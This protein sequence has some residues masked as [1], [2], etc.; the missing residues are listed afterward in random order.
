MTTLSVLPLILISGAFAN[1]ALAGPELPE[2]RYRSDCTPIGKDGRHGFIAEVTITGR[3]LAASAQNYAHNDCDIPT[4][5]VSYEGTIAEVEQ[6][7][8]ERFDFVQET[9]PFDY[10][11]LSD[12]ITAYYNNN[13]DT[14]GCGIDDWQ[15]D[16][17]RNVA[18][19]ICAP[20]SFPAEGT[21]LKDSLWIHD[22]GI[23]FGYLPTDWSIHEAYPQGPSVIHFLR[24]GD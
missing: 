21:L 15:T 2:G 17:P 10:A 6:D 14:A 24:V 4:V 9:G 12:D 18:G 20:F 3:S 19:R 13:S 11:L 16:V 5:R 22:D 1:V 23:A 8:G 7:G